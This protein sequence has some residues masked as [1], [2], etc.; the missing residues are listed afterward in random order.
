M[1][2]RPSDLPDYASP[3]V[4]EV[5]IGVQFNM[6]DGLLAPHLGLIWTEFKPQFP[7][8]EQQPPLE[9]VFETF[10]ERNALFM[11]M[12]R[13]LLNIPTPRMF[14]I[15]TDRTELLQVQRDRFYHNW[16]KI[17]DGDKYPRFEGMLNTFEDGLRRLSELVRREGLGSIVPNQCE[18][19]YVNYI[20]VPPS[21]R[22]A[23]VF[24]KVLGSWAKVPSLEELEA[25]EDARIMVRYVIRQ[26]DNVPIGR[27]IVTAEPAWKMDGT[28][29]LQLTLVARGK[30]KGEVLADVSE[31]LKLGRRHIV[32][33][34]D[35]LTSTE[36]HKEWGKKQ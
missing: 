29:V 33:G 36:M 16:R 26:S 7:L 30:P 1:T 5:S 35:E 17:G 15:N 25:P 20:P 23:E 9:P 34:F 14:F 2:S 22:P 4:A 19:T 10:G 27:L 3:P 28:S 8:M 32:K 12:P 18:I 24:G 13:F 31:F 21:A 11:P 6:L